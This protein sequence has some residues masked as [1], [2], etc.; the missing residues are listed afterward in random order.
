MNA[1]RALVGSGMGALN[2]IT[3]ML[4]PGDEIITGDDLYGGTNRLLKC[5]S[6]NSGIIVHYVD[7]TSKEMVKEVMSSKTTM[8]L[9]DTPTNPLIKI[10]DIPLVSKVTH[11]ANE[12]ALVVVDNS[13]LSP[14][15]S[16][17]LK[18]GTSP[19]PNEYL[20]QLGFGALASVS[21]A[22]IA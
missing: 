6:S 10:V 13:M 8:V 14:M 7:T 4:R 12:K 19:Y 1:S 3:R 20:R 5:L 2:V 17:S 21:D 22:S 11:Q 9:L 16:K 18:L 15:L